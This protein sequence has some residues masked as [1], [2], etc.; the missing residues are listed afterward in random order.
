MM[1]M[2]L[3]NQLIFLKC[4][5]SIQRIQMT[6][7]LWLLEDA[8]ALTLDLWRV[9]LHREDFVEVTEATALDRAL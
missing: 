5:F 7:S 3:V 1:C 9:N 4:Q 2:V 6:Y 8:L